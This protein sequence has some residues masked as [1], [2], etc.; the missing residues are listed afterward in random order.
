MASLFEA[1][2]EFAKPATQ[3]ATGAGAAEA[4]AQLIKQTAET[5]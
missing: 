4:S 1:V 3:D 2:Y 5:S